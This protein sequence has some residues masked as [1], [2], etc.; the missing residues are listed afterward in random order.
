MA[1]IQRI[2][3]LPGAGRLLA[4]TL[5]L[6]FAAGL[7]MARAEAAD[8]GA[9][10]VRAKAV[11]AATADAAGG[12]PL[13]TVTEINAMLGKSVLI[14]LERPVA[15]LSVGNPAVADVILTSQKQLYVLGKTIGSTNLM[16]WDRQGHAAAVIDLNVNRELGALGS[17]I[18]KLPGSGDVRVRS[19]GAA[20]V[21][22]G[23]VPDALTANKAS[24]L[25]EAFVGKKPVNM[26]SIDGAQQVMLEVKVA[27]INRTLVDS[28]GAK[29]GIAHLQSGG[30]IGWTL[31]GDLLS[32]PTTIALPSLAPAI[33][34]T[35]LPSTVAGLPGTVVGPAFTNPAV[36]TNVAASS[37]VSISHTGAKMASLLNIDMLKQDGLLKILAE[38]NIVAMSGQ[39]GGFLAGGE[40]FI[41]V[42]QGNGTVTME[43]HTFG[44]GLKFMPTVLEAGRIHMRVTPEVTDVVGF[45]NV[46]TGGLGGS[47]IVPTL[48]TRRVSTT[49]EL[50]DGQT[51]AIGGLLNDTA[52]EQ[53]NRLP[54]LGEIPILGALFRSSQ[55]QTD[56][57][58][59]VILVTPRLIKP[60]AGTPRLPTDGFTPPSRAAFFLEGSM[61]GS[62]EAGPALRLT[63]GL[64]PTPGAPAPPAPASPASAEGGHQ[65]K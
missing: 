39:E 44:V 16:L 3:R 48:A 36:P 31:L 62:P 22:E 10:P 30:G 9:K 18:Q 34:G 42:P 17:E 24:D 65:L 27:E 26:L 2:E 63:R 8:T 50:R 37:G 11:A 33:Q 35:L 4:F 41:P 45:T 49:V 15:R 25:A 23:H 19:M 20:I 5:A 55:Y 13:T 61:E 38:P 14:N 6:A 52:K 43:S 40:I 51:L 47:V 56:R 7:S 60:M 32:S 57:T 58:E 53:I 54:I 21:L 59:L 1:T 46:A 64:T 29:L 28:L 12:T